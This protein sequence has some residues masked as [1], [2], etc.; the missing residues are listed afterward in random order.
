MLCM[1]SA[2]VV[3]QFFSLECE[4]RAREGGVSIGQ[5]S[6]TGKSLQENLGAAGLRASGSGTGGDEAQASKTDHYWRGGHPLERAGRER[7]ATPRKF[8][9]RDFEVGIAILR[10]CCSVAPE[11]E[12]SQLAA[13]S[14]S[15]QD[16]EASLMF[17]PGHDSPRTPGQRTSGYFE[18]F[19]IGLL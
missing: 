14:T 17:S 18:V 3:D 1:V 8:A 2:P 16:L 12:K 15:R 9:R 6:A 19:C 7:A 11:C 5:V 4:I 13:A 10:S